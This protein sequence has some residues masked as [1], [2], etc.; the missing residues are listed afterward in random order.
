MGKSIIICFLLIWGLPVGKSAQVTIGADKPPHESAMLDLQASD[1]GFLG[2][3][4][5]LGS[6]Y[7]VETIPDA[8]PGLMVLNISEPDMDLPADERVYPY[9]LY[10]WV[11]G[12]Q[13]GWERF[14]GHDELQYKLEEA[15]ASLSIPLPTMLYMNGEDML[16][17]NRPGV[18]NFMSGVAQ[19][20]S[21]EIPLM[22]SIN[23]SGGNVKLKDG[24]AGTIILEPC[25][26]NIVFAYLFIPTT[27]GSINC[28]LSSY[29]MDFPFHPNETDP[30]KS[31]RV[32]SN[33][34]HNTREK[35]AHAATINFVSPIR[36]TTEWTVRLGAGPADC[37]TVNGFSLP[38]RN[39]FFYITKVGSWN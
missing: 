22:D 21:K 8:V 6:R 38:N 10:Y 32:Y 25:I 18:L 36:E 37:T 4:V 35:S 19:G 20:F 39:T 16:S 9:R 5:S 31:I 26:Y 33:T 29:F 28:N 17:D 1:K 30:L 13:P 7:D 23:H 27:T 2:P 12:D 15:I 11:G 34:Y 14:I 3:R 24:T